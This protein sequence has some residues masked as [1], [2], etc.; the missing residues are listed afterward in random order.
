MN[1]ERFKVEGM[2]CSHCEATVTRTLLKLKGIEEV[3]AD[4]EKSEIKVA[5]ENIDVAEIEHAVNSIGYRFKGK[6]S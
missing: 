6:I 5:G 2:T 1:F 4:R 3:T